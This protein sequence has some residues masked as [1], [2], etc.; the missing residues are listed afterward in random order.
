MSRTEALIFNKGKRLRFPIGVQPVPQVSAD[1]KA[2]SSSFN[3]RLLNSLQGLSSTLRD[4][5]LNN[6]GKDAQNGSDPSVQNTANRGVDTARAYTTADEGLDVGGE[7]EDDIPIASTRAGGASTVSI[8]DME[9]EDPYNFSNSITYRRGNNTG[10]DQGERRGRS[11]NSVMNEFHPGQAMQTEIPD[12]S[13]VQPFE[14]TSHAQNFTLHNGGSVVSDV[15]DGSLR[16]ST[17]G[18]YNSDQWTDDSI[19]GPNAY[20]EYFPRKNPGNP[21][22]PKR[23]TPDSSF[24]SISSSQVSQRRPMRKGTPPLR[25]I[26]RPNSGASKGPFSGTFDSRS[27]VLQYI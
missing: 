6:I 13:F 9:L 27:Q 5:T 16:N 12:S 11:S 23:V 1:T 24:R 7:E 20:D 26:P 21:H 3:A 18:S 10:S 2:E 15:T 25:P 8:D 14:P 19:N 4:V 17:P 22:S